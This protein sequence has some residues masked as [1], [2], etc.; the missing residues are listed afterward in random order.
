MSIFKSNHYVQVQV[1]VKP[2][3]TQSQKKKESPRVALGQDLQWQP[4]ILSLPRPFFLF[5]SPLSSLFHFLNLISIMATLRN[6][7]KELIV[8]SGEPFF[9]CQVWDWASLCLHRVIKLFKV[10]VLYWCIFGWWG[11]NWYYWWLMVS[12]I[13]QGIALAWATGLWWMPLTLYIAPR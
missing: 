8:T 6:P 4:S 10:I 2:K 13:S 7:V 12:T 11:I 1:E 9:T 5:L 3:K